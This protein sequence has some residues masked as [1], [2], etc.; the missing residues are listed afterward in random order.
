V[1]ITPAGASA[2]LP[3][4]AWAAAFG[5]TAAEV[6]VLELLVEGKTVNAAAASLNI[7]ATTART[8]LARVMQK[9]GTRRQAELIRLATQL[10][11][12]VR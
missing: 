9:T 8:H 11:A 6:R 1:F 4:T 7:A 5:L 2:A 3:L 10:I 12:P